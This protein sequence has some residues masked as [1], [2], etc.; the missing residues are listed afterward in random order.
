[1]TPYEYGFIT[2]CAEYGIAEDAAL[3]L[4]KMRGGLVKSAALARFGFSPS[5]T[6][7]KVMDFVKRTFG[8]KVPISG[9]RRSNYIRE[10][11]SG[12]PEY[13][14]LRRKLNRVERVNY[15]IRKRKAPILDELKTLNYEQ[16]VM[17]GTINPNP[18]PRGWSGRGDFADDIVAIRPGITRSNIQSKINEATD[19]L[20]KL[21]QHEAKVH[22][23][24][25][26]YTSAL[27]NLENS[28]FNAAPK[29][30]YVW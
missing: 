3:E 4:L 10:L 8:R 27:D 19:K 5:A 1:M 22:P 12:N 16:G 23:Y 9:I 21:R 17:D 14:K 20:W 26:K 18:F 2:K 24:Y 6:Y 7:S 25:T 15:E 13:A 29:Y 11:V 30:D 28:A